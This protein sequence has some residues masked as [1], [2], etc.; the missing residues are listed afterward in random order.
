MIDAIDR[1]T[2]GYSV[3]GLT[4][5]PYAILLDTLNNGSIIVDKY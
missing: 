3:T 4:K 1:V 2:G 5:L